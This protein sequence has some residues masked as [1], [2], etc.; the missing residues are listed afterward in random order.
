MVVPC[1]ILEKLIFAYMYTVQCTVMNFQSML[2]NTKVVF[3]VAPHYR[4][5]TQWFRVRIWIAQSRKHT[6]YID[7]AYFQ[8]K[9]IKNCKD[10]KILWLW[11]SA[12]F[13]LFVFTCYSIAA[14]FQTGC[15]GSNPWHWCPQSNRGRKTEPP[16]IWERQPPNSSCLKTCCRE[17]LNNFASAITWRIS[18]PNSVT[19]P[20]PPPAL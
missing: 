15:Q 14:Q 17:L 2:P 7:S 5:F 13:C 18:G 11:C 8:K 3:L 20:P 12:I 4:P 9:R 1:K 6:V 10:E 16:L 19:S